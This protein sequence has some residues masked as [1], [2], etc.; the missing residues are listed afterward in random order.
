MK[1]PFPHHYCID[2]SALIDLKFLYSPNT[3]LS[4]WRDIEKLVENKQLI[5]PQQVFEELN[6]YE[7]KED[8]LLNWVKK[9]KKMF[10]DLDEEQS[11]LVKD[12][13]R[14]FSGLI[15]TNKSTPDADPFV[16]ALSATEG[17]TV[18]TSEKMSLPNERPRIPNVCKHYNVKCISLQELFTEQGWKY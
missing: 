14:N 5:S 18:I 7:D 11:N 2:T 13:L 4:L 6:E 15:D 17:H 8:I 3:F 12:I 10:M 16:I 1:L 9:H